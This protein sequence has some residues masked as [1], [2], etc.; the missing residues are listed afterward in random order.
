MKER[1]R[2]ATPPP[3]FLPHPSQKWTALDRRVVRAVSE[4]LGRLEEYDAEVRV[5]PEDKKYLSHSRIKSGIINRKYTRLE[6]SYS[7]GTIF[8][9]IRLKKNDRDNK[10]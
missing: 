4:I 10:L 7:R 9:K 8:C 6:W 3:T 5:T 2:P 1:D